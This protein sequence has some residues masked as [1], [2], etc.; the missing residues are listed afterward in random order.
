M[1]G[2]VSPGRAVV[3]GG[4]TP[5]LGGP[6]M[7]SRHRG[8]TDCCCGVTMPPSKLARLRGMG[9]VAAPGADVLLTTV[10]SPG[11]DVL[12][13]TAGGVRVAGTPNW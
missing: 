7:T 12:R 1:G 9:G 10:A 5:L 13:A 6:G 2:V 3:L 11:A 8:M 4:V